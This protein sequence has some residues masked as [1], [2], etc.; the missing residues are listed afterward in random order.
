MQGTKS[1]QNMNIVEVFATWET[2]LS[3]ETPPPPF[4]PPSPRN[5]LLRIQNYNNGMIF[6]LSFCGWGN[7]GSERLSNAHQVTEIQSFD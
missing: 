5:H 7:Q 6:L 2:S 3:L 4:S 1:S